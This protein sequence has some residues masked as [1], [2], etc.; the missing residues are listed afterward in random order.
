MIEDVEK[1]PR[2]VLIVTLSLSEMLAHS[3]DRFRTKSG[4]GARLFR[5]RSPNLAIRRA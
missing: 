2:P 1:L 5:A 4:P 3:K